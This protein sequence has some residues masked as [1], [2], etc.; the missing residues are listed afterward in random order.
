MSCTPQK[1]SITL[2]SLPS[3]SI[4]GFHML[5]STSFLP[6]GVL[7][8]ARSAAAHKTAQEQ[9]AQFSGL[10]VLL[11]TEAVASASLTAT[12]NTTTF[13][14]RAATTSLACSPPRTSTPCH[15]S[16]YTRRLSVP[17]TC[18]AAAK[19]RRKPQSGGGGGSDETGGNDGFGGG[20]GGDEFFGG[21]GGGLPDRE[22]HL[23]D[24]LV[25]WAIFCALSFA[26]T[27]GYVTPK[28]KA[29]I[30]FA[31]LSHR[32]LTLATGNMA[33]VLSIC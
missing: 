11:G 23:Q 12:S 13:E 18:L 14:A 22:G 8:G 4:A 3:P 28:P 20:G 17:T 15:I 21:S 27:V 32:Q 24:F 25:L 16:S 30:I 26:Q 29:S 33:A 31:S 6:G 5:L 19:Q 9:A 10:S 1:R 7:T 2:C